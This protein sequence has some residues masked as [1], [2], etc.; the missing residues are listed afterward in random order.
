MKFTEIKNIIIV[1][2]NYV[3]TQYKENHNN[4]LNN[5]DGYFSPH[6]KSCVT[7]FINELERV[8]KLVPVEN[9]YSKNRA[10]KV[11]DKLNNLYF[12]KALKFGDD[13]IDEYITINELHTRFEKYGYELLKNFLSLRAG[14]VA[15]ETE[16][17]KENLE[18][19][20]KLIQYFKQLE[21]I[22][23]NTILI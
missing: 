20:K 6:F 15:L 16:L 8:E 19:C 7:K 11:S 21:K 2:I 3:G 13:D 22:W 14:F 4:V 12:K 9:A 17:T 5:E 10:D 23:E 18:D 1:F